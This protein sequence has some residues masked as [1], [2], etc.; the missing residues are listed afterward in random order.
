MYKYFHMYYHMYL[1]SPTGGKFK[2]DISSMIAQL[3]YLRYN[4]S[5]SQAPGY[6]VPCTYR[7]I[8]RLLAYL[9]SSPT[10][11]TRLYCFTSQHCIRQK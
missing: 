1:A 3:P 7:K 10:L 6:L 2:Y 4:G 11:T 8:P 5:G 9:A